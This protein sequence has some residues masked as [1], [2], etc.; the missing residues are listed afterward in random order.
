MDKFFAIVV[1]AITLEGIISYAKMIV[2]DQKVQWQIIAAIVAGVML[3][4]VYQLDALALVDVTTTVPYVGQI[5]TGICL[6]RGSNY[7]FDWIGKISHPEYKEEEA[8]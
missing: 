1:M 7:I 3:C 2:V 4:I 8:A 5:L 6:S